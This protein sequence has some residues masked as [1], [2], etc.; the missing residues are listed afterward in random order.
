MSNGKG[1]ILRGTMNAYVK[2]SEQCRVAESSGNPM[3]GMIR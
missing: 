1:K 3:I 2:V